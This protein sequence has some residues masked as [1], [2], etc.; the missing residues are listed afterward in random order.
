MSISF[1]RDIIGR[2]LSSDS[3]IEQ[4]VFFCVN[5]SVAAVNIESSTL[6]PEDEFD[7]LLS[8]L[9]ASGPEEAEGMAFGSDDEVLRAGPPSVPGDGGGVGYASCL[10]DDSACQTDKKFSKPLMLGARN[11]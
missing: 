9:I 7:E 5:V 6:G 3:A 10:L 8:L 2:N 4:F 1:A 11:W